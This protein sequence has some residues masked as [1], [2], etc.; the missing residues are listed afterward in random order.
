[1]APTPRTRAGE[2]LRERLGA[3]RRRCLATRA[4]GHSVDGCPFEGVIA[5]GESG[6][7]NADPSNGGGRR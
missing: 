3:C 2:A 6:G 1:M 5:A 7:C 4:E